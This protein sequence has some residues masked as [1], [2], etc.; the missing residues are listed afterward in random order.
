MQIAN[1]LTFSRIFCAP[2]FFLLYSLPIW[3][4]QSPV[5]A[6]LSVYFMI[7]LLLLAEFTDYLDGKFARDNNQVSN[8]GKIFDPFADVFLNLTVFFCLASSGYMPPI[9]FLLIMYREI[10]ITFIRLVAMQKSVAIGARKG[11]K[12]KTVLYIASGFFA[13][14]VE[15][16]LRIGL[17]SNDYFVFRNFKAISLALFIVCLLVSYISFADYFINFRSILVSKDKKQQS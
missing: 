1:I 9:V 8:F 11:G 16:A 17:F 14:F 2:V 4:P 10:S 6:E 5:F 15:S 13:L 3:F 7:P 12:I